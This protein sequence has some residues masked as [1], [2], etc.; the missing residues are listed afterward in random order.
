[1]SKSIKELYRTSGSSNSRIDSSYLQYG[2][3][4]APAP[5]PNTS[6]TGSKTSLKRTHTFWSFPGLGSSLAEECLYAVY[7]WN[8]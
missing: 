5:A 4:L 3:E 1:M 8:R 2:A 6:P 7:K